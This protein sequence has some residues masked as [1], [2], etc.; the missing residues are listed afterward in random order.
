MTHGLRRSNERGEYTS[1]VSND[2]LM[3]APRQQPA[4]DPLKIY[5]YLILGTDD[6]QQVTP[7]QG[8]SISWRALHWALALLPMLPADILEKS[9]PLDAVIAQRMGGLRP[10]AWIPI[11]IN[12]LESLAP[13]LFGIFV[14]LFSGEQQVAERVAAWA[15]RTQASVLHVTRHTLK[16]ALERDK[17]SID[18]L[19]DHCI[20]IIAASPDRF[21]KEQLAAGKAALA[22]WKTPQPEPSGLYPH[23]HNVVTPNYMRRSQRLV[24]NTEPFIGRSEGE[25]TSIILESA[26]AVQRVRDEVGLREYHRLSSIRPAIIL[27]EPA[28]LRSAYPRLTNRELKKE[29]ATRDALRWIQSQRG[30]HTERQADLLAQVTASKAAMALLALRRTELDTFTFGIGLHAAQTASAVIRLSPGVNHVFPAQSNY[31][32]NMRS[33]GREVQ[34]KAPRLFAAVQQRL[35]E[36][37]GP[38]R[39]AYL[40]EQGGSYRLVTDAPVEWLS[41]DGLPLALRCDCTRINATP[42][43]LLMGLLTESDT[44]IY[45]PEQLRKILIVSSFAAHD[46]LSRVLITALD[47]IRPSWSGKAEITFACASTME[48]FIRAVNAFEGSILVFDGHGVA[49][50]NQL[51]GK[52]KIGAE[53]VDVWELRGQLRIPPIVIL[54]ACDTHGIDA[55]SQATVGNGFLA[56]G[57][58]TVVATLLPV[59]GAASALFIARLVHRLADFLPTAVKARNWVVD[60]TEV[61]SGMLRMLLASELLIGLVGPPDGPETPRGNLEVVTGMRIN[62]EADEQWFERVLEDVTKFTGAGRHEVRQKAQAI[63]A[64][65]EAIRYVQL[66]RPETILIDDGSIHSQSFAT[67]GSHKTTAGK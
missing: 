22:S 49:N 21:S 1:Q 67:N 20:H 14:V 58:R 35:A 41:I 56:I 64:C 17:F 59:G 6:P 8:F 2:Q 55:A 54:S 26:R 63:I 25:Y 43:N 12:T 61:V 5:Y 46:P 65:S 37:V 53:S 30:L 24:S 27:A 39:I 7:L 13:R 62:A 66:G 32:R 36:A 60:W 51:I 15:K 34:R 42:G 28:L 52:L 16:G 23:G 3:P 11:N 47:L 31:A 50:A 44:L 38:E 18:V 9:Y 29:K 57:A 33:G 48:E 19:R 45:T 4:L 40:K 10:Q